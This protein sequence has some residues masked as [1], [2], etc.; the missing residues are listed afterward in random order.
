[1]FLALK[2]LD[3]DGNRGAQVN[4][5][6]NLLSGLGRV[7]MLRIFRTLIFSSFTHACCEN[8]TS[9]SFL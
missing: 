1:M 3:T 9:V 7:W 6:G 8:V 4:L 2:R 5:S